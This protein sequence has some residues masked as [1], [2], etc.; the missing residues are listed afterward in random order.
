MIESYVQIPEKGD[1]DAGDES[2]EGQGHGRH[3]QVL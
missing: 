1:D 3:G 2:D